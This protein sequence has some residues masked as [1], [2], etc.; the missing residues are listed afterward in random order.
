MSVI[1]LTISVRKFVIIVYEFGSTV[2]YYVTST[3]QNDP[4][5]TIFVSNPVASKVNFHFSVWNLR[6]WKLFYSATNIYKSQY[7]NFDK[8][9][10]WNEPMYEF[11]RF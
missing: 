7:Y 6:S 9:F 2:S 3:Y 5:R 11:I 8:H 4:S 1:N 10:L